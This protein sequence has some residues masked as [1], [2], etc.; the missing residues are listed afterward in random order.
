MKK[1]LALIVL[2][3]AVQFGFHS[4]AVAATDQNFDVSKAIAAGDHKGLADYYKGQADMYRQKASEHDAMMANY[5]TAH[6]Y[7]KGMENSFQAHCTK[8]KQDALDMADKYDALAKQEEQ[9]IK[10]K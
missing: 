1:A 8:L 3:L 2:T 5:K 4:L 9:L 7:K 10:G 6:A